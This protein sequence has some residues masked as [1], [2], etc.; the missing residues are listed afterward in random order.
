[1]ANNIC[2][3]CNQSFKSNKSLLFH[4]NICIFNHYKCNNIDKET[5]KNI[6]KFFNIFKLYKLDIN[7]TL[8][9][10][11]ILEQIKIQYKLH[12]QDN[13]YLYLYNIFLN[14]DNTQYTYLDL[15]NIIFTV[16]HISQKDI[17]N[18]LNSYK[19]CYNYLS[20]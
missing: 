17:I 5:I 13:Y 3:S 4:K 1:M 10:N 16:Y 19:K 11:N 8:Y 2:Y 9:K 20:I 12:N 6:V 15:I 14:S 18:I 7:S